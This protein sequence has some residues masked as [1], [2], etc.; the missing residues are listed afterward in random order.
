MGFDGGRPKG[1][2]MGVLRDEGY[3]GRNERVDEGFGTK[4][5]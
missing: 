1:G 5:R 3:A 2:H 4:W